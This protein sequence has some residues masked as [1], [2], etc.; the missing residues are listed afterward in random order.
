MGGRFL[1]LK[2]LETLAV[3]YNIYQETCKIG[4]SYDLTIEGTKLKK[5]FSVP[6]GNAIFM[7]FW[8][9]KVD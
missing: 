8:V 9:K 1:F 2:H 3:V 4:T 7:I 5:Y 6:S